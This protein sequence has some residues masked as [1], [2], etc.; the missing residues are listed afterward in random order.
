VRRITLAAR[1][2]QEEHWA[3]R[4]WKPSQV[5]AALAGSLAKELNRIDRV[6]CGKM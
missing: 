6:A 1:Y 2:G 3:Y 4:A 5:W